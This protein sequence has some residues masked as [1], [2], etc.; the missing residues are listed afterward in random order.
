MR[1]EVKILQEKV[2]YNGFLQMREYQIEHSQYQHK[3]NIVIT[4]EVLERDNVVI[5][6]P[7]DPLT[8]EVVLVQQF[9]IGV[10]NKTEDAWITEAV[11]GIVEEGESDEKSVIRELQEEAG[12][13]PIKLIK[14]NQQFPSAGC[15]TE[16]FSLYCA[17][18]DAKKCDKYAGVDEGE[19]I[20]VLKLTFSEVMFLHETG[21]I[22]SLSLSYLL[23]WLKLNKETLKKYA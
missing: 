5:V 11:A 17:L 9:R 10:L 15:S 12:L 23:L 21:Q 22:K 13:S 20:K 4:R 1:K 7:Y 6:L 18:V 14:I 8:D 3:E 19:D 2:L 16:L